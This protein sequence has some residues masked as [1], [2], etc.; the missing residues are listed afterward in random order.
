MR[1]QCICCRRRLALWG[2][3]LCTICDRDNQ[4]WL[5]AYQPHGDSIEDHGESW[6]IGMACVGF[7]LLGLTAMAV[8]VKGGYAAAWWPL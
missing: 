2:E 6:A 1:P 5:N 7:V 8:L 3:Q 4:T